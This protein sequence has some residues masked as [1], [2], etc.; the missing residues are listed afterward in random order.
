[1]DHNR[2]HLIGRLTKN[3]EFLPSGRRG[4]PH[5]TFTL[6]VNRVVPNE[7]GPQADYIP[8]SLWGKEAQ[9]F[10]EDRAKGDEVG[11]T[12]R[13]R[14]EHVVQPDGS[15]RFFWEVRVD[16]VAYGRKS[17]KN[18]QGR[19]QATPATEAVRLLTQEFSD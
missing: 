11:V 7:K 6:A 14:T 8:C 9:V 16:Q 10:A 3:P 15:H 4:E 17:L 1:M 5:C 18:L 12:G 2:V 19:P 13:L